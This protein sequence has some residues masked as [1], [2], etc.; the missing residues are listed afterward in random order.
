[1]VH[2]VVARAW[3]HWSVGYVRYEG[4]DVGMYMVIIEDSFFFEN[5]ANEKKNNF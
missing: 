4:T 3:H 1:M 2:T 5:V